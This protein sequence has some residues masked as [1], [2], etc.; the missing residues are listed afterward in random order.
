M[1][2]CITTVSAFITT[3]NLHKKYKYPINML[4]SDFMEEPEEKPK[5]VYR[6][7]GIPPKLCASEEEEKML[8]KMIRAS[9]YSDIALDNALDDALDDALDEEVDEEIL[10]MS[11]KKNYDK[12]TIDDKIN[13]SLAR[14]FLEDGYLNE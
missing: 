12:L 14:D 3:N 9:N 11:L 13:I 6:Y 4:A 10:Y 8:E 5:I 1:L 7:R 2:F